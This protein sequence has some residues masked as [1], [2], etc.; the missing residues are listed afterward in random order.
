MKKQI[1]Y[2]LLFLFMAINALGLGGRTHKSLTY[3]SW[4][5][6][7]K[8][9]NQTFLLRL[10]LDK[11]MLNERLSDGSEEKN[12]D[13]WLQYGAEHE[14]DND[15][16]TGLIPDRSNFHFHNPLTQQSWIRALDSKFKICSEKL[17]NFR[18]CYKALKEWAEAGLSD[19][20]TGSS[21]ILWAQKKMVFDRYSIIKGA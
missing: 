1:I 2:S 3:Y 14:D 9:G 8:L 20:A 12:P 16:L 4:L 11:G 15:S 21:A 18:I 10:N 5:N 19:I 6:S 13:E 17:T 7:D